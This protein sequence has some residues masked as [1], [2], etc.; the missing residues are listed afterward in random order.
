MILEVGRKY[1]LR[2]KY[3]EHNAEGRIVV[4]LIYFNGGELKFKSSGGKTYADRPGDFCQLFAPY[5]KLKYIYKR[6]TSTFK[7]R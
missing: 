6:R 3:A 1:R 5:N 4:T 7:S 2:S